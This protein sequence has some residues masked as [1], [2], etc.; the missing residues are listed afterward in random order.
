V[1][2]FPETRDP[3]EQRRRP[4]PHDA[5]CTAPRDTRYSGPHRRRTDSARGGHSR[6]STRRVV[7]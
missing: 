4:L 7:S 3:V 6:S 5:R 2:D 1:A